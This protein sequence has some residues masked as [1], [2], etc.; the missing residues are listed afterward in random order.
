MIFL[1]QR[2]H[3]TDAVDWLSDA[4]LTTL[5]ALAGVTLG[6]SFAMTKVNSVEDPHYRVVVDCARA[7]GAES[8]SITLPD[9]S[10]PVTSRQT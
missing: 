8:V 4:L 10:S 7:L 1:A 6:L 5:L 3:F 9:P 2:S